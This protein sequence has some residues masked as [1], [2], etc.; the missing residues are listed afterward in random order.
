VALVA[1]RL[2]LRAVESVLDIGCGRGD[3][4]EVL[5]PVV[6]H[7]AA[8][9]V[10][11]AEER[12]LREAKE[13][14]APRA[15]PCRADAVSLC[16]PNECFDL[17]TCQTVLMH[18]PDPQGA[19][20]EMTRVTRAG[21]LVICAE[22]VNLFARVPLELLDCGSVTED[23]VLASMHFWVR[24]ERGKERLGEGDSSIGRRLPG[25]LAS[26]G[27]E[28]VG[29]LWRETAFTLLPPYAGSE[30]AEILAQERRWKETGTGPWDRTAL[31][32]YFAAS[33]GSTEDFNS[34]FS[35]MERQFR[36][37]EALIAAR[38][39]RWMGLG[40]MV[41]AWGL[42]GHGEDRETIWAG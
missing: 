19:L 21:G 16:F 36:C 28:E 17:V 2:G 1:R 38:R 40:T 25:L 22:P 31:H 30:A 10:L 37:R 12:W 35:A 14:L 9:V 4:S 20:E 7:G 24:I 32:R 8:L 3:W 29:T 6:G 39:Y 23:E 42:K 13:R 26:A 15:I 11:D 41:L 34:L 5:I 27:L 18:L 33:G